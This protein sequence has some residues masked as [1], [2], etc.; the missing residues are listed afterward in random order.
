MEKQDH[1][2]QQNTNV[3]FEDYLINYCNESESLKTNKLQIIESIEKELLK[4]MPSNLSSI[5]NLFELKKIISSEELNLKKLKLMNDTIK[6]E[7]PK[8]ENNINSY[9]KEEK[10]A[11]LKEL[12]AKT[13]ILNKLKIEHLELK[14]KME[15]YKKEISDLN[16]KNNKNFYS[17]DEYL[18][19][20][21][22]YL[23]QKETIKELNDELRKSIEENK[24]KSE[25]LKMNGIKDFAGIGLTMTR[26]EIIEN[27]KNENERL[28]LQNQIL[29]EMADDASQKKKILKEYLN[30]EKEKELKNKK[31]QKEISNL[32]S[33]KEKNEKEYEKEIRNLKLENEELKSTIK[34]IKR[35]N[36]NNS[37]N[38]I[39]I[40]NMID[41]KEYITLKKEVDELKQ[42]C[43]LLSGINI[44]SLKR[45]CFEAKSKEG[46]YD[47]SAMESLF[48][49]CEE[50][51]NLKIDFPIIDKL[52]QS[53]VLADYNYK[54]T[55]YNYNLLISK[56]KELLLTNNKKAKYE[57]S[58]LVG[59]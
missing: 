14:E 15:K 21:S 48:K 51:S 31:Y 5:N 20:K 8:S 50:L 59:L 29:K 24:Q 2:E 52:I 57:L 23:K 19:L 26:D 3:S 17:K 1:E 33:E 49:K 40:N 25:I 16:R 37:I 41:T 58:K 42:K 39:S 9:Q 54:E 32:K 4:N 30:F 45:S 27:Y 7:S 12:E 6:S 35:N 56:A 10:E 11:L 34:N 28:E 36:N 46:E 44:E 13:M 18:S 53:Y 43:D 55:E 22:E 38:N 47:K